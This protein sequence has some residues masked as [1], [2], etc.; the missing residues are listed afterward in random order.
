MRTQ[1]LALA[2]C[3]SIRTYTVHVIRREQLSRRVFPKTYYPGFQGPVRNLSHTTVIWRELLYQR[4]LAISSEDEDTGHTSIFTASL[5]V[6]CL[7]VSVLV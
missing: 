4:Y 2:H 6:P 7:V 1:A 5:E 3:A